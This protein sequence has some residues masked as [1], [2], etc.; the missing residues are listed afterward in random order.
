LKLI[1]ASVTKK[2]PLRP[3]VKTALGEIWILVK[4][5]KKCEMILTECLAEAPEYAPAK[6]VLARLYSM[7]G[8]HAEA[9]KLLEEASKTSPKNLRTL[10]NLGS[11]LVGADRHT[12]ANA[13]FD[14]VEEIDVDNSDLKDERAKVAFKEGDMPLAAQLLAQTQNGDA[15]AREFNNFAIAHTAAGEFAKAI[16]TYKNA[17]QLLADKTKVHLLVYNLGLAYRKSGKLEESFQALAES[18]ISEPVFEKAY[19]ALAKLAQEYKGLGKKLD[20]ELM[21]KIKAARLSNPPKESEAKK[22]S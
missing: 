8:R 15:M 20:S 22:A 17:I 4:Q 2:S 12:D 9:I 18:Y 11:A 13:I 1:D 21:K 5:H 16:E 7:T 6:Y 3:R 19:A 14:K 10:L